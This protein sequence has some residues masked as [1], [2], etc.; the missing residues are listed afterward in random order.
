MLIGVGAAFDFHAGVKKQAP[1][2]M[3]RSGLE[4]F[5]RLM[6]EPRRLW[7]RYLKTNSLFL[8][9]IALQATGLKRYGDDWSKTET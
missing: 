3:Q 1:T 4:W 9:L 5:F 8:L 6:S 7:R 2:W